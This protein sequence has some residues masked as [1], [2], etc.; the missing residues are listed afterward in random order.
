MRSI[1]GLDTKYTENVNFYIVGSSPGQTVDV[2]EKDREKEGYP[3]PVAEIAGNGL[4]DL[5]VINQSTKIALDANGV[6]TYRDSFGQG[7]IDTWRQ[8][9]AGLGSTPS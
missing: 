2:L 4:R 6:I 1:K 5:K 9:L 7:G 8:V 3:W